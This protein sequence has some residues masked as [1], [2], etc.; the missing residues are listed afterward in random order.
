MAQFKDP[1]TTDLDTDDRPLT[2]WGLANQHAYRLRKKAMIS[3]IE[4]SLGLRIDNEAALRR[5]SAG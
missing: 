4:R 2:R 3:E 1:R 5:L